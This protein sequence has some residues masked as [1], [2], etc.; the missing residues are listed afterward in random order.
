MVSLQ[1]NLGLNTTP[2]N[3]YITLKEH[4]ELL[5]QNITMKIELNKVKN[6]AIQLQEQNTKLECK[7]AHLTSLA[8]LDY[9][10]AENERLEKRCEN[11]LN[12]EP[13]YDIVKPSVTETQLREY[14]KPY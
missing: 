11:L 8:E 7:Q 14:V 3:A 5:E 2:Q 12:S 9:F 13:R 6:L 1:L 10:E 4:N